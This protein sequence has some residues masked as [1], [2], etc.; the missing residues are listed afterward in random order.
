MIN[1]YCCRMMLCLVWALM[2]CCW[3]RELK[4]FLSSL[5]WWYL[6]YSR[7]LSKAHHVKLFIRQ[8]RMSR[9]S[10]ACRTVYAHYNGCFFGFLYFCWTLLSKPWRCWVRLLPKFEG[11]G[12]W[13][14][15]REKSVGGS[16]QRETCGCYFLF[17]VSAWTLLQL[18]WQKE[19]VACEQSVTFFRMFSCD[20]MSIRT[21]LRGGNR[22]IQVQLETDVNVE[23]MIFWVHMLIWI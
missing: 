20:E 9:P 18:G 4:C 23:L 12:N 14:Q 5:C 17:G 13:E 22:L 15:C 16:R 3:G 8:W 7:V 6:C 19:H 21:K 2:I 11:T 10:C 1:K